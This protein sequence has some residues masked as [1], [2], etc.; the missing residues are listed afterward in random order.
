MVTMEASEIW[1]P[2]VSLESDMVEVDHMSQELSPEEHS[3][4]PDYLEVCVDSG[5]PNLRL[6]DFEEFESEEVSV[7]AWCG[8]WWLSR[9]SKLHPQIGNASILDPRMEIRSIKCPMMNMLR[10]NVSRRRPRVSMRHSRVC[11][12]K[13]LIGV[14]HHMLIKWKNLHMN[15]RSPILI[16]S[17]GKRFSSYNME[18][19]W[20]FS[21]KHNN[22]WSRSSWNLVLKAMQTFVEWSTYQAWYPHMA[23]GLCLG[24]WGNPTSS[25]S[26]GT[27]APTWIKIG[28]RRV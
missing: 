18:F 28:S 10:C 5:I 26:F 22:L 24:R 7:G 20:G 23:L 17:L 3:F 14:L 8:D 2:P 11:R 1:E 4:V 12:L 25:I 21:I 13:T 19:R 15:G 16:F 6:A 27:I 9:I